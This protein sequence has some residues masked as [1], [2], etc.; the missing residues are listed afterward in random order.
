VSVAHH[1]RNS[2]GSRQFSG[3]AVWNV[4]GR[5]AAVLEP[6]HAVDDGRGGF[7]A[8]GS[9]A[10]LY[11]AGFFA[12]SDP[13]ADRDMHERRLALALDIDTST[14]MISP[15]RLSSPTSSSLD[16]SSDNGYSPSRRLVWKNNEWTKEGSISRM[17]RS[18]S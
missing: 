1:R 13:A 12:P 16:T 15:N 3:G 2:T 11:S 9:S 17:T 8:S 5:A 4:G 10:P 7:V 6:V 18:Y 14:R